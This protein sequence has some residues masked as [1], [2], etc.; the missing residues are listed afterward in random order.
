MI[1]RRF[2]R[3]LPLITAALLLFGLLD[4]FALARDLSGASKRGA[5]PKSDAP[6]GELNSS[7][8]NFGSQPVRNG[9]FTGEILSAY[10]D[11]IQ[12]LRGG[13]GSGATVDVHPSHTWKGEFRTNVCNFKHICE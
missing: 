4:G 8:S 10:Y 5:N 6:M 1:F 9:I 11:A 7:G 3:N 12:R 13:P 2:C